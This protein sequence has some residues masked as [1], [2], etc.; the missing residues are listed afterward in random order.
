MKRLMG[1]TGLDTMVRVASAAVLSVAMA[2]TAFAADPV[3]GAAPAPKPLATAAALAVTALDDTPAPATREQDPAP[4]DP[5][6]AAN[7]VWEFFK[8]TEVSGF[9]DG[10]YGPTLRG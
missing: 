7:P 2:A 8:Q 10:Y 6:P 1:R 9:V 5:A 3:D 4:Q